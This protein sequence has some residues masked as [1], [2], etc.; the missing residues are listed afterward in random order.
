[1][2]LKG[3]QRSGALKLAAHLLNDRDND[4]VELHELRGFTADD[5]HGALREALKDKQAE[6]AQRE[7]LQR[8]ARFRKGIAGAWDWLSGK[9]R[10]IRKQNEAEAAVAAMRDAAEREAM[11]AGQLSVR[12]NLQQEKKKDR[13][14][15]RSLHEEMV[16]ETGR[17]RE[18]MLSR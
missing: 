4:H 16:R 1:M 9:T 18:A 6:R 2:I 13:A 17:Y 7:A 5:L 10:K 8:T 3:S 11:I 14:D 12:R 15:A